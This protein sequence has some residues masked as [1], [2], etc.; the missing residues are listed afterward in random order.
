MVKCGVSDAL[1][2]VMIV[3]RRHRRVDRMSRVFCAGG[4]AHVGRKR[5][6]NDHESECECQQAPS[7]PCPSIANPD[8]SGAIGAELDDKTRRFR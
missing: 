3:R 7:H 8:H 2:G 5:S 6:A 1:G 4:L